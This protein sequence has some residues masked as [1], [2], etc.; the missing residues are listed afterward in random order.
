MPIIHMWSERNDESEVPVGAW[1]PYG[2]GSYQEEFLKQGIRPLVLYKT[3]VG[4]CIEDRERNYYDDSDFYMIVWNPETQKPSEI[5][6]AST[7]GWSY[8]CYGSHA[9]ATPEVMEAYRAWVA[10]DTKQKRVA[11]RRL[12][13]N[14]DME[15]A[16][17]AGLKN[18]HQVN[19]IRVAVGTGNFDNVMR[20]LTTK[21][22]RNP[23]RASLAD[24]VRKWV[25]DKN[26]K[27]YKPLTNRQMQYI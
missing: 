24:Q 1:C 5:T 27:Y 19:R 23:F 10:H 15:L 22:F 12:K 11:A 3:H 9:D 18:R 26:P 7:R 25:N 21:K 13:R 20:L 2:P 16:K 14:A 8:P 17:K 4:L 6:F